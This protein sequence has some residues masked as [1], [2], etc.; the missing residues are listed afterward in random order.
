MKVSVFVTTLVLAVVVSLSLFGIFMAE[1]TH[2]SIPLQSHVPNLHAHVA[3]LSLPVQMKGI[4]CKDENVV[5]LHPFAYFFVAHNHNY[6]CGA[7]TIKMQIERLD[8]FNKTDFIIA[9]S[10]QQLY[11]QNAL[12]LKQQG[13]VVLPVCEL[14]GPN[15]LYKY[16]L[17]RMR[18]MGLSKYTR[19]CHL[20]VDLSVVRSIHHLF[21]LPD[22]P[23]IATI[24]YW[25]NRPGL[26]GPMWIV[27]PSNALWQRVWSVYKK[28]KHVNAN[29]MTMIN[30]LF[31]HEIPKLCPDNWGFGVRI[32]PQALTLP[33]NYM[34]VDSDLSFPEPYENKDIL[35]KTLFTLHFTRYGKPMNDWSGWQRKNNADGSLV[36]PCHK[37][38]T[39]L[40][41]EDY[42]SVCTHKN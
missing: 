37:Q 26:A 8:G 41:M 42:M 28:Y 20:D 29:D 1:V 19:V 18:A 35:C 12:A 31:G 27:Q 15:G 7:Q 39:S 6:V 30:V 23:M 16:S 32:F 34:V 38:I 25:D 5:P 3:N 10:T 11:I 4:V 40:W 14:P 21:N 22:T 36:H 2:A 13:W 24:A 17:Q 9:L 33:Y